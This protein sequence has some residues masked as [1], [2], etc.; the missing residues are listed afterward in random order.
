MKKGKKMIGFEKRVLK[1]DRKMAMGCLLN[2]VE[3]IVLNL[4]KNQI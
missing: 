3:I 2:F 4:A 1:A